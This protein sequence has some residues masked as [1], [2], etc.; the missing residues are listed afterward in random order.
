MRAGVID[1]FAPA[2]EMLL[3]LR[4]GRMSS[5]ELIDLHLERIARFN[6]ALNAVVTLDPEAARRAA[7]EADA[8]RTRSD[9]RPLLGL[10]VTIKDSIDVRGLPTT[11]GL[12]RRRDQIATVDA[13]AV[14]RLRATGAVILGKT[15]LPPY[16]GDW[17]TENKLFG[18]SNNPWDLERT[19][20]GSTGGG[21]AAVA[22]GL[23]P[24]EIGSDIGGS[25]RLPAAFCG[26]YGHRPSDSLLP[27]SGQFPGAT[28]P[29][30]GAVLNVMGPLARGAADLELALEVMAGPETGEEPWRIELPPPRHERLDEYR[31]AVLPWIDWQPVDPDVC[32][33]LEDLAAELE[34]L[35]A[36]TGRAQPEAMADLWRHHL[37]YHT[38]MA[39][40][41]SFNAAQSEEE[42]RAEAASLQ[43]GGD[44]LGVARAAG[45]RL[46]AH[47]FL[48]LLAE[49]ERYRESYRDFFRE[50]DVLLTPAAIVPAFRHQ[51]EGDEQRGFTIGG[52]RVDY[53]RLAVYPGIAT[54]SGQP[55]TAFPAGR[56]GGG[57]PIGLQAV[58]PYLE[59]RTPIHFAR[60]LAEHFGGYERPPGYE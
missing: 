26:I 11:S 43:A 56:T 58:G 29:N 34:R 14:A 42:A 27:R 4:S 39:A 52:A 51:P 13:P 37:L 22:A 19:P 45:L 15:N 2:Q 35:G 9:R 41:F 49:R 54:F 33:C 10:P 40:M 30:P 55:A 25:I 18:R 32:R 28:L 6:P 31:V 38:L 8:E 44:E 16:T 7:R 21:A 24:L 36:R 46:S 57:L 53:W 47:R 23:S 17:Q 48:E 5:L 20:G 1:A 60:L 59:D 50:W 12:R 3:D